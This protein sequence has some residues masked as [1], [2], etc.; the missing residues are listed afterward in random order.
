MI[1]SEKIQFVCNTAE[2]G[3]IWL[4]CVADISMLKVV[5]TCKKSLNTLINATLIF[6]AQIFA[7]RGK[8]ISFLL[9]W[10]LRMADFGKD[11][12]LVDELIILQP[13]P[14]YYT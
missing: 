11:T 5:D 7:D 14:S 3:K 12:I 6:A 2:E 8:N 4:G 1:Q 10:F 9:R 13:Y